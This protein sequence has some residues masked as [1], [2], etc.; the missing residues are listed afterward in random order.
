MIRGGDFPV[1]D[2]GMGWNFFF[3]F[4]FLFVGCGGGAFFIY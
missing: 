4:A 1:M 3:V 2:T